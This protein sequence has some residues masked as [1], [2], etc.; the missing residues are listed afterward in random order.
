M[1]IDPSNNSLASDENSPSDA[2][3][4]FAR[5]IEQDGISSDLLP[6]FVQSMLSVHLIEPNALCRKAA[7][8]LSIFDPPLNPTVLAM[9]FCQMA[10]EIQNLES[11]SGVPSDIDAATPCQGNFRP[12]MIF[13]WIYRFCVEK[14]RLLCARRHR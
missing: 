12:K 4:E 14:S 8:R 13:A 5:L 6:A 1:W 3:L 7:I 2:L 9:R 11:D 10:F